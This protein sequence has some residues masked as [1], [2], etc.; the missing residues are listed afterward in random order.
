MK[1]ARSRLFNTRPACGL[2]VVHGWGA[3]GPEEVVLLKAWPCQPLANAFERL[4]FSGEL[5][6]AGRSLQVLGSHSVDGSGLLAYCNEWHNTSPLLLHHVVTG[7]F[8]HGLL[9][10]GCRQPRLRA[11]IWNPPQIPEIH[12][13]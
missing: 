13:T 9:C 4:D 2:S 8:G 6:T 12:S 5:P 1:S 11:T 10:K 7:H 3:R